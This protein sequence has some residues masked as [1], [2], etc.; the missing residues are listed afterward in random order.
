LLGV[1]GGQRHE[2]T[3]REGEEATEHWRGGHDC[4]A[5]TTVPDAQGRKVPTM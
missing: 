2:Q 1:R 3:Q 5:R 4:G